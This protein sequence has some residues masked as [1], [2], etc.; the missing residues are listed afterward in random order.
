MAQISL[1]ARNEPRECLRVVN[2]VAERLQ[3]RGKDWRHVYKALILID[4]LL[5]TGPNQ[6]VTEFRVHAHHLRALEDFSYVDDDG[7]DQGLHS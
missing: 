6:V 5:R 7:R 1:A 2:V 4:Y 3:D